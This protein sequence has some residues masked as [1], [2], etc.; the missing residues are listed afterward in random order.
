MG[1]YFYYCKKI[2]NLKRVLVTVTNDLS[3][4]Q[5]VDKVCTTLLNDG[6]RVLLIGRKLKNS[7][8]ISRDYKTK[9]IQLLFNQGFLF[10]AEYNFRIFLLLFFSKKDILLSNDL[11]SLFANYAVSVLQ[12]KKLVYDSHELFPEIPELVHRPFVKKFW[13]SLEKLLLP[14]LKNTYT[15]CKSI[16][17]Y[18]N[19]RYATNF[20][21][22]RNLPTF[23]KVEVGKLP[24]SMDDK[25]IIIYQGALNIG[26]GLELMIDAM[27][28][29]ENHLLIIAGNGDIYTNL[30]ERSKNKLTENKVHFL[31]KLLPSELQKITPL[32]DIGLSLE[33]DLGLNYRYALPNKIFDYIQAEIPI[34][35][36]NLPEM[37]QIVIKY[38]VGEIIKLRTPQAL[39]Y[40]IQTML[41]NEYSESI[42]KAKQE[43]TWDHEK[44]TLQN[45][46]K[47]LK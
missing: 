8:P 18:Y 36:S 17:D 24:F 9:R 44:I 19:E 25:K 39:A 16:A 4:D 43:L 1:F 27:E 2:F 3:T 11:D 20:K 45:I 14:K 31:G 22:V 13:S 40:Q 47:N 29:L 5:R 21:I 32:A 37:K 26:R 28:Y 7:I 38:K 30:K 42:L 10:Y 23:K 33:E 15:V 34:L 41:K 35:V 12:N 46:F 6:Y